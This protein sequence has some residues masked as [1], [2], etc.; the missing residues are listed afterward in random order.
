MKQYTVVVEPEADG[1]FSSYVP[2][3]PGCASMGDTYEDAL[4]NIRDAIAVHIEGLRADN[5][6]IPEPRAQVAVVDI[7]A[8]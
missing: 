8:A 6:P 1:Q 7:D 4:A 5:L 3:L 2:D